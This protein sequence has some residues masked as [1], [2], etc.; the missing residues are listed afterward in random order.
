MIFFL[1]QSD[2]IGL[3]ESNLPLYLFPQ[4]YHFL[5]FSLK[6]QAHSLL[7]QRAIVSPSGE[8]LFT[9]SPE[10]INKILQIPRNDYASPFSI[11][12]LTELYQKLSF[13]QTDQIFELF[14][15]E[16]YQLP[17]KNPPYHSSIFSVKG[18]QIIPSLCCLL[19]Y[20]SDEWVDEPIMGFLSIF[21]TEEKDTTQFDYSQFLA[22][23]IHEYLFK[24]STVGMFRYSSI[25]VYMF[26][27][28]QADKLSFSL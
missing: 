1:D 17:K 12:I 10:T 6:C 4:T 2:E 3:W 21:S 16:N 23:N 22:D 15:P 5:E 19:G 18:N 14:L 7:G 28:F 13:P 11:E 25:L 20:Y 27:F 26:L 9:M 24:F 8:T